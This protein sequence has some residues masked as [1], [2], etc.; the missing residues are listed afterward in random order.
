MSSE[1]SKVTDHPTLLRDN[2]SKALL[3]TDIGSLNDYKNRKKLAEKVDTLAQEV[4]SMKKM[5]SLILT[6]LDNDK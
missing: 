1:F 4:N 5:L 3:N 2:K 6:K